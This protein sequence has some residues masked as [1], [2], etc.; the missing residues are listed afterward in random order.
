MTLDKLKE[1][2]SKYG[3]IQLCKKD[4]VFTLLMTGENLRN[5]QL[6]NEIQTEVVK[7]VGAEY[8]VIECMRNDKDF[9][10]IVLRPN[11]G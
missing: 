2:L 3:T 1:L 5:W 7:C 11:G 4:Y 9:F 8:P 6:V 10:C